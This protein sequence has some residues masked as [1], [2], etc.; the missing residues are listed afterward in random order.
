MPHGTNA[1]YARHI[2]AG[3][4]PCDACKTAHNE[5]QKARRDGTLPPRALR[6]C[7]TLSAARRHRAHKEPLD[8][9]CRQVEAD[10]NRDYKKARRQRKAA[11]DTA[12]AEVLAEMAAA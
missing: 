1:A 11:F 10:F 8:A 5:E 9:E 4:D 7:G 6:P 3:E 12:L 2:K